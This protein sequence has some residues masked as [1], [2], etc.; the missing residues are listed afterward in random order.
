MLSSTLLE[1]RARLT[2]GATAG[3]QRRPVPIREAKPKAQA[4]RW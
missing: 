2:M 1:T 3:W 4:E